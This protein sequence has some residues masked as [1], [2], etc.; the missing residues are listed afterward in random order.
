MGEVSPSN[1]SK[2]KSANPSNPW[3]MY[4]ENISVHI[5]LFFD[6]LTHVCNVSWS[7]SSPITLLHRPPTPYRPISSISLPATFIL[8]CLSAQILLP[9]PRIAHWSPTRNMPPPP[10]S[11]TNV[12]THSVLNN[13]ISRQPTHSAA[14]CNLASSINTNNKPLVFIKACFPE[15]LIIVEWK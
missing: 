12:L 13:P 10:P 2:L 14:H 8:T 9:P 4:D 11:L 15:S 7:Y 6:H 1:Y 3:W 5:Y